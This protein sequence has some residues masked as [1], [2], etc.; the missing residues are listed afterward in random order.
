MSF[1]TRLLTD[2]EIKSH[3]YIVKM[4]GENICLE[5]L[6]AIIEDSQLTFA[7][8]TG[9]TYDMNPV[10][11]ASTPIYD[12]D[13]KVY[14]LEYDQ[15]IPQKHTVDRSNVC[16]TY[17]EAQLLA[18]KDARQAELQR[19]REALMNELSEIDEELASI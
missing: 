10:Y 16:D 14:V 3:G 5:E 12:D 9:L 15:E 11:L 1:K 19:R 8:N 7:V 18:T 13:G 17:K 6:I 2:A 4:H